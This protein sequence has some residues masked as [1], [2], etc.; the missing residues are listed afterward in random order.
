[1]GSSR[2]DVADAYHRA[3][4]RGEHGLAEAVPGLRPIRIAL[5]AAPSSS[6]RIKSRASLTIGVGSSGG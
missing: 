3:L 5:V 6:S 2:V 4:C 1:M